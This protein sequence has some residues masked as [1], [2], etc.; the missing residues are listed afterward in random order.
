[1]K[2]VL[3]ICNQ[4][5]FDTE[6]LRASLADSW[7]FLVE[8]APVAGISVLENTADISVVLID[9][10]SRK[11]GIQELL[12][13]ISDKNSFAIALPVLI[14]TGGT[15]LEA[16]LAY[17]GGPVVDCIRYPIHPRLLENRMERAMELINSMT[18][19]EFAQVLKLLPANI[20]LKDAKARYVFST[21]TWHH[22]DMEGDPNWTIRGKTDPEIRKDKKNAELALES[23]LELI[24]NGR[25]T[26]YVIEENDDGKREFLQIIKEPIK[27][28]AGKVRGI[29]ALINNVTEQELLRRRLKKLSITDALTGLYNRGYL[30]EYLQTLSDE[31]LY[32]VS[33]LSA[34]CDGL[35]TI[36]DVYGHLA[37]DEYIRMTASLLRNGLPEKSVIF[38]TGGDEFVAFLPNTS[39]ERAE[40]FAKTLEEAS[41]RHQ[42]KDWQLSV[43]FG[44]STLHSPADKFDEFFKLSDEAMYRDKQR[45]KN[46]Q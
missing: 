27:D 42:I 43:S 21:Q 8:S 18:F 13:Y 40:A 22:L 45:K 14:L 10:P 37:G 9:A 25:G 29:I 17:L 23:D 12:D 46:R 44:C 33:I 5:E 38:R 36:N 31:S 16:D 7:D 26:A 28:P 15:S 19:S 24:R 39:E 41:G 34:D 2:K 35:K 20:Y 11:A 32:P 3:L 1:M 30:D 4:N 6:S